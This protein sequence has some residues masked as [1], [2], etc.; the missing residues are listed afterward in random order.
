[1]TNAEILTGLYNQLPET[2][3][4]IILE[5]TKKMLIAYDPEYTKLLF[6]EKAELKEAIQD[7]KE[8]QNFVNEQDIDW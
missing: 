7:M 6:N 2:D 8:G 3:Q 4:N 5:I 1:M